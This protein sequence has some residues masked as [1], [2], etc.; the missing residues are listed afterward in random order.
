[1]TAPVQTVQNF[2][3]L[4][5]IQ[6]TTGDFSFTSTW[7]QG[8]SPVNFSGASAKMQIRQSATNATKIVDFGN[9]AGTTLTLGGSAGTIAA[10][11]P[12]ALLQ[13]IPTGTYVWDLVVTL[14][15]VT[16]N[17]LAGTFELVPG[18]SH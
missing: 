5:F 8:G 11:A 4:N 2:T 13:T 14:S 10:Y 3:P 18:V 16:T 15:G 12:T 9:T 6:S 7:N 17:W 1:M